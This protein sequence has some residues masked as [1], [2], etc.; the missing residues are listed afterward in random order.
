MIKIHNA[1][2]MAIASLIAFSCT[3][4]KEAEPTVLPRGSKTIVAE[5]EGLDPA[6]PEGRAQLPYIHDTQTKTL[7]NNLVYYENNFPYC[8]HAPRR[9][10]TAGL[11]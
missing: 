5:R 7:I 6:T 8:M 10:S 4:E 3:P 2:L 11:L 1:Y 9:S